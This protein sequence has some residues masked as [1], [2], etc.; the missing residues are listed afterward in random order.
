MYYVTNV[1]FTMYIVTAQLV[2][3]SVFASLEYKV[4]KKMEIIW[5]GRRIK[6]LEF[7][8]IGKPLD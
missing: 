4:G 5:V 8:I 7:S 2:A 6:I 3:L 1:H